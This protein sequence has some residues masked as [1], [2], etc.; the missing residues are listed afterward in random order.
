MRTLVHRFLMALVWLLG[1]VAAVQGQTPT[2]AASESPIVAND[3]LLSNEPW[4]ELSYGLSLRPP[5]GCQL[6]KQ[7]YDE[8]LL[9]IQGEEGYLIAVS[10]KKSQI[11][12][13]DAK[14][15][16]ATSHN[17]SV[18]DL[19][20]DKMTAIAIS[21][22]ATAQ[23]SAVVIQKQ[24]FRLADRPAGLVAF[25]Y[26]DA[27][28]V[29]RVF[30]QTFIQID[31][32]VF[33]WITLEAEAKKYQ[34][35]LP[36]YHALLA[37]VKLEDPAKIEAERKAWLDRGQTFYVS[38]DATKLNRAMVPEQWF[39]LLEN[40][41]DIGY[42]RQ[43]QGSDKRMD[44]PGLRVDI[45]AHMKLDDQT[46]DSLSQMFVSQDMSHEIWSVGTTVRLTNPKE[47]M[48]AGALKEVTSTETGIRSKGQITVNRQTISGAAQDYQWQVPPVYLSQVEI[49]VIQPMLPK[50][51]QIYGFYAYYP[52]LGK[53]ALRTE[54]VVV[55]PDGQ[56]TVYSRP[57][58]EQ[59]E[60]VSRYDASGK[61]V[62]R[63]LSEQRRLVPATKTEIMSL[64]PAKK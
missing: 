58:P 56:V 20:I 29:H 13:D 42:V 16:K 25:E 59:S 45:Q 61:L 5:L 34:E 21:Q 55:E 60:Q 12:P 41:R 37:G 62:Y 28:R 57:S 64:W 17:K 43:L 19:D 30:A 63:Q 33:V 11:D 3:A 49:Q 2:A 40:G 53:M 32:T 50:A 48:P 26:P 18:L 6:F 46:V 1:V 23:P 36:I 27:K 44:M 39:R 9:R 52:N 14:R 22:M 4:S 54:R 38:L 7:A 51:N 10:I 15:V 47:K 31:P 35:I 8:L 24:A